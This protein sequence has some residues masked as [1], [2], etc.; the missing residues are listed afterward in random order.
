MVK[1]VGMDKLTC[2]VLCCGLEESERVK[3]LKRSFYEHGSVTLCFP[4][5]LKCFCS[6][7]DMARGGQLVS[8]RP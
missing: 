1:F 6:G 8:R 5:Y 3:S 2:V 7:P 4:R